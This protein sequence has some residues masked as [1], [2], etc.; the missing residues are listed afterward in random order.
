MRKA[1]EIYFDIIPL[2]SNIFH[3]PSFQFP[4]Q[5]QFP[6]QATNEKIL[7]I[8]RENKLILLLKRLAVIIV[9]GLVL[10]T[11][12]VIKQLITQTTGLVIGALFQ[13][14]VFLLAGLFLVIGWWWVS[15]IWQKSIALVTTK[16][17]TKFIYTTPVSRY[18]LT[19]PLD[20]IVDTGAYTKGFAQTFLKLGTFIARSS[21]AS[22][23]VAT[24]DPTRVN[25]KY[26]YIENVKQAED[27]QHYVSKVLAATK[28]HPDEI[29]Q[30][31]PF[32]PEMKGETRANFIKQHFPQYWS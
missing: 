22:S 24:D 3:I 15:A 5:Y 20:R 25:K 4:Y 32:I 14:I 23:G 30:F 29:K 12:L 21:A 8:T 18:S 16:R 28:K 1:I 17:L 10:V 13:L 26:F 6:G 27:L 9:A 7:Y 19:L 31:R 11:G 2:M